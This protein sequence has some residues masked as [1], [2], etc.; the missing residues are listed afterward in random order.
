MIVWEIHKL[1]RYQSGEFSY[2]SFI[3]KSEQAK[4]YVN[5]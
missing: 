4:A 3:L 1:P 5:N 2:V